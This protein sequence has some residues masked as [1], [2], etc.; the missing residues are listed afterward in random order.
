M[1]IGLP[2]DADP[3]EAAAIVAALNAHLSRQAALLAANGEE[4]SW[5]GRR[6]SFTGRLEAT[7]RRT[8]RVP[9]FAPTDPWTAAARAERF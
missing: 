3:D 9:E 6:W 5:D 4:A 7:R 2:E 1:R 8:R